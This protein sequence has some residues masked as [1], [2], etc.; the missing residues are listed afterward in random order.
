VNAK[1]L[2]NPEITDP[3]VR[4]NYDHM[5]T[6]DRVTKQVVGTTDSHF[7]RQH[8]DHIEETKVTKPIIG[9]ITLKVKI[10]F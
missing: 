1:G 7:Y 4:I 5:S 6:V 2:V 8:N 10:R 9:K 3:K